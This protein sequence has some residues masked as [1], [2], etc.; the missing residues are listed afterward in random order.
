MAAIASLSAIRDQ[1][2]L[3]LARLADRYVQSKTPLERL[4]TALFLWEAS[5]KLLASVALIE[6]AA[7]RDPRQDLEALLS[8]WRDPPTATCGASCAN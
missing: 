8:S 5:L 3:P 2:P 4:H 6:F 7:L 1:L